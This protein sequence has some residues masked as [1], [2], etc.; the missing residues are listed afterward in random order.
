[1][2]PASDAVSTTGAFVTLARDWMR[3]HGFTMPWVW[4]QEC[5]EILGQHGHI[6]LHV[7]PILNDLFSPMPRRWAKKLA[8]GVY[9]A[10]MIDTKR[11][12]GACGP[13]INPYLYEGS[14]LFQLHY[15]LKCAPAAQERVLD[16][17]ECGL[18]PW[19][20]RTRV[21]GKRAGTWQRQRSLK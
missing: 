7:P 8:G 13:V 20:Q 10:R 3:G 19:G 21:V 6:L 9:P 4:T 2:I 18:K 11:L 1:M 16:M 15:M 17:R 5:G 12:P 14:L